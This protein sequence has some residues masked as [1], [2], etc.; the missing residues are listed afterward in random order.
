MMENQH[1]DRGSTP[2]ILCFV[3]NKKTA[4]YI[5]RGRDDRTTDRPK[6]GAMFDYYDAIDDQNIVSVVFVFPNSGGCA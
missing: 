6:L 2:Q 3:K 4:K 1:S 5:L